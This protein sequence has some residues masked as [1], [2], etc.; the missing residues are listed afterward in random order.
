MRIA[1]VRGP[2]TPVAGFDVNWQQS[3]HHVL[4]CAAVQVIDTDAF[5]VVVVSP[6][7]HFVFTPMLPST[8]VGTVE[9]R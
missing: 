1:V 5:E 6:R 9:F 3:S 7:N 4:V 8:A 2:A